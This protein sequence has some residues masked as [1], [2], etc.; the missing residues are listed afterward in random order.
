MA[1]KMKLEIY[2]FEEMIT[3]L[4]S[5]GANVKDFVTESLEAVGEEVGIRTKEALSD[6]PAGGKYSTGDTEKSVIINPTV[7]WQGSVATIGMGFDKMK[8]GAGGFLISGT[9]RMPPVQGLVTIYK[10]KTFW[11]KMG[12][13]LQ[14]SFNDYFNEA[15]GG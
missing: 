12:E 14:D 11:K 10:R 4:D 8:V 15:M 9:P 13:G 3:A 5:I 1:N 6:L 2:G 7:E